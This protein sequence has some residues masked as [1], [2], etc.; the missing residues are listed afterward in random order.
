MPPG[1]PPARLA[2]QALDVAT[3][4]AMKDPSSLNGRRLIGSDQDDVIDQ[5][6]PVTTSVPASAS[7]GDR[8][9]EDVPSSG[10]TSSD[11]HADLP[12][13]AARQAKDGGTAPSGDPCSASDVPSTQWNIASFISLSAGEEVFGKGKIGLGG[14]LIS[15][16]LTNRTSGVSYLM[17]LGGGGVTAGLP[18]GLTL[19]LPG[20]TDFETLNG[21]VTTEAFDLSLAF[22]FEGDFTPGRGGSEMFLIW[23][24]TDTKPSF[25]DV[26]GEQVGFSLGAQVLAGVTAV[27]QSVCK[28]PP[29]KEV[30]PPPPPRQKEVPHKEVAPPPPKS[31]LDCNELTLGEDVVHFNFGKP[32]VGDDLSSLDSLAS[33]SSA[34]VIE[35]ELE[36]QLGGPG[37]PALDHV[38]QIVVQGHTDSRGDDTGYD[39][40]ALSARRA[41]VIAQFLVRQHPNLAG[42][43]VPEAHGSNDPLVNDRPN[44][45]YDPTLGAQN[46]RVVIHFNLKPNAPDCV[47]QPQQ[48]SGGQ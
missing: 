36:A 16:A 48:Q 26:G 46:R 9:L 6:R 19:S 10:V 4:A 27:F 41:D 29:Q 33:D 15:F 21:P 45:V 44:G 37:L 47:V 25:L 23:A 12:R 1:Q 35:T 30:P 20:S 43:V 18:F 22:L 13:T 39:N 7:T 24:F 11:R 14:A 38:Q 5:P 31:L 3:L 2:R 8:M 42:L 28:K 34:S 40:T 32:D 17:I